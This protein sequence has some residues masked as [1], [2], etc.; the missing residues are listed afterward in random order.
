[1]INTSERSFAEATASNQ[2]HEICRER[3]TSVAKANAASASM[4]V[5]IFGYGK[6]G[7]TYGSSGKFDQ[8]DIDNYCN[9][10][11]EGF[12]KSIAEKQRISVG[13][14][15]ADAVNNCLE[16]ATRNQLEWTGGYLELDP[17]ADDRFIVDLK[18]RSGKTTE[19]YKLD[20]IVGSANVKCFLENELQKTAL[21]TELGAENA[22]TCTREAGQPVAARLM[23]VGLGNKSNTI[24]VP[25]R[26]TSTS[27]IERLK[28]EL[29]RELLP[30]NAIIPFISDICPTGW[31]ELPLPG[32]FLIGVSDTQRGGE[33]G[34][35]SSVTLSPDN[36]PPHQHGVYQHAG[37]HLGRPPAVQPEQGAGSG[38]T[39]TGVHG[40]TTSDGGFR[41]LPF[42]VVPPWIAVRY[43]QR[44]AAGPVASDAPR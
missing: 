43:C 40:G 4:Q 27:A 11:A 13:Q 26:A 22:Y 17:G 3:S 31:R 1:L 38:D 2:W 42:E 8:T 19:R 28:A 5:E 25:I 37:Y 32:R 9:K 24:N 34:G 15:L 33:K 29:Q 41:N 16:L 7:G 20:Q 12:A 6:G 14:Y 39:T 44:V 30:A 10:G 23:F 18:H 36:L 21:G 35:N